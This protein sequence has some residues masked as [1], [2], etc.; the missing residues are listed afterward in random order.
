M[1][2]M[3]NLFDHCIY[4]HHRYLHAFVYVYVKCMAIQRPAVD[5]KCLAT[6]QGLW[7]AFAT[8]GEMATFTIV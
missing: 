6:V 1:V 2:L 3:N 7:M 5:F 4:I 8:D